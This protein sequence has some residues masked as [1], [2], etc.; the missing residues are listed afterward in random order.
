MSKP[1]PTYQNTRML[2]PSS[3]PVRRTPLQPHYKDDEDYLD[4]PGKWEEPD[5]VTDGDNDDNS[6]LMCLIS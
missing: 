1:N 4:V 5:S 2:A 3:T 6:S